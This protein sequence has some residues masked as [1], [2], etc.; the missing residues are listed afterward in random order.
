MQRRAMFLVLAM[1]LGA[2]LACPLPAVAKTVHESCA[3][4]DDVNSLVGSAGY[5]ESFSASH[6]GKLTSAIFVTFNNLDAAETYEVDLWE[7]DDF[8]LPTRAAPLA[9]STVALPAEHGFHTETATFATPAKVAKGQKYA[10]VTT[11][12]DAANNGVLVGANNP[13][14]GTFALSADGTIG[15]FQS[16]A[17]HHDLEFSVD[18]KIKRHRHGH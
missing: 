11:V 9:S 10:L 12:P 1:A 4:A 16:D 5:S 17:Q 13:C 8:G 2:S 7:A 3:P 18:V 14:P 15:G 6:A